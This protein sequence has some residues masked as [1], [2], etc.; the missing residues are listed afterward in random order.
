LKSIEKL[1]DLHLRPKYLGTHPLHK[2]QFAYQAGRPTVSALHHLVT[3]IEKALRYK[4]VASLGIR[5]YSESSLTY[6]ITAEFDNIG[7]ESIRAAAVSRQT[8]HSLR[9]AS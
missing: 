3:K 8:Y 6:L 7:F 1:I 4:E 9:D 2:I 5:G